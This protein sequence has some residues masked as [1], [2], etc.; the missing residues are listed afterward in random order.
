MTV[1]TPEPQCPKCKSTR[2]VVTVPNPTQVT[3]F[4]YRCNKCSSEWIDKPDAK[5]KQW[6]EQ[7]TFTWQ[8]PP[9]AREVAQQF[10]GR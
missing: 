9:T 3:D 6:V 1:N 8:R 7:F 10:G 5:R 2:K 4:M